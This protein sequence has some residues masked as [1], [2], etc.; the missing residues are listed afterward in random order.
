MTTITML[1]SPCDRCGKVV[2]EAYP[3][4]LASSIA[5]RSKVIQWPWLCPKCL[6]K[7]KEKWWKGQKP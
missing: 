4:K 3:Y 1:N 2:P 5:F 7:E 6:M